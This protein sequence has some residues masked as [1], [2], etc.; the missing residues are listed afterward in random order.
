MKAYPTDKEIFESN[1]KW[2]SKQ[3]SYR[4]DTSD[5]QKLE[6]WQ[7]V[8]LQTITRFKNW[9]AHDDP[10]ISEVTSVF[11]GIDKSLEITFLKIYL[12]V[13]TI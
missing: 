6:T 4:S 10:K 5:K 12:K 2:L 13:R 8:Y 11:E 3:V 7:K 9:I 1:L